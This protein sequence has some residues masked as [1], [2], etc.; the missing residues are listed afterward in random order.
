MGYGLKHGVGLLTIFVLVNFV[1]IMVYVVG[2]QQQHLTATRQLST[3][4]VHRGLALGD[5]GP[6]LKHARIFTPAAFST[7]GNNGVAAL[8]TERGGTTAFR[9]P[10]RNAVIDVYATVITAVVR[11]GPQGA[12]LLDIGTAATAATASNSIADNVDTDAARIFNTVNQVSRFLPADDAIVGL[13][14]IHI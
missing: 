4:R 1:L 11:G 8:V 13:S 12:N 5:N 14:L 2:G 6:K 10:R 3:A 7:L 9:L